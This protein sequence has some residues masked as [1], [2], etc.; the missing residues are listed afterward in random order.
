MKG[1]AGALTSALLAQAKAD[2]ATL[3]VDERE[4]LD[5]EVDC[6]RA[7]TEVL[8]E[9]ADPLQAFVAEHTSTPPILPDSPW[10]LCDSRHFV[11]EVAVD[12]ERCRG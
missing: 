8:T 2:F 7:H 3:D 10:G 6:E 4:R 11:P 12:E 5:R 9:T 1:N